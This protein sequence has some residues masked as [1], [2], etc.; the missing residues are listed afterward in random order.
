MKSLKLNRLFMR[1]TP[2]GVA[3]LPTLCALAGVTFRVC[4]HD[5]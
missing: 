5:V 1:A 4:K 3:K 2:L